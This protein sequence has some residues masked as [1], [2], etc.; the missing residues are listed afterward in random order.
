MI[1]R[2]E[3]AVATR[4]RIQAV[5]L[6]SA[7]D[8]YPAYARLRATGG[9]VRG[10]FGQWLVTRHAD[11]SAL[12]RDHRLVSEFPRDFIRLALG[13]G[14]A[15]DFLH[16]I[17]LTRDPPVHTRLRRFLGLAFGTP[18]IRALRVSVAA[19]VD[20]LMETALD[21]RRFDLVDA[22][23]LPLPVTVVC[24]MIGI[25]DGDQPEVVPRVIALARVFDAANLTVDQRDGIVVALTWLRTYLA[26]LLSQRDGTLDETTFAG[27]YARAADPI[28]VDEFIDN[29][30]FLFHAGF[31]TTMGLIP[32]GCVALMENPGELA[33]LRADP[34]LVPTAV[35]EFLRFDSPIQNAIR[36]AGEPIE[37]NDIK[38]RKGR[39]VMLLLGCA[40]R[41]ER[42]FVEPDRLDVGRRDNPHLGFGGGLHHCVG[43]AVARLMG[44]LV[45]DRLIR[46]C[47]SIEPDGAGLRRPHGSLRAFEHLPI[48][49]TPA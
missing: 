40:N 15:G 45:F 21:R 23:A 4:P 20:D 22:I 27:L 38:I 41:D 37:I 12:L 18:A 26:G 2:S 14:P 28:D 34:S 25:P 24:R 11:A 33:R 32:N 1:E 44:E 46:R 5:D 19:L 36:V 31:E 47:A 39:S 29:L 30:L 6:A 43:M 17:V 8:P 13:G 35:D 42:A 48:A 3:V 9:V 49:V 7:A 10:E 16:R